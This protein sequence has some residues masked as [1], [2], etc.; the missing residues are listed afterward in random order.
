MND[1]VTLIMTKERRD[2]SD[3][4]RKED[5]GEYKKDNDDS[6]KGEFQ[7]NDCDANDEY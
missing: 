7:D 5:D 2:D 3:D 1:M 4:Y 6:D